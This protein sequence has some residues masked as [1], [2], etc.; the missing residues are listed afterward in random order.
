M[1]D[2]GDR[3]RIASAVTE[4]RHWHPA[5][6]RQ[7]ARTVL[8]EGAST[9]TSDRFRPT[10]STGETHVKRRTQTRTLP[11]LVL[12]GAI[13]TVLA[14]CGGG[15]G[16][17]GG[18]GPAGGDENRD[19]IPDATIAGSDQDN[20]GVDDV[21]V[22][23]DGVPDFDVNQDGVR[24]TDVNR[25]GSVD[26]SVLDEFGLL[27]GFDSDGDGV[28]D[29]D[30][31]GR[32]IDN[33]PG[34]PDALACPNGGTDATSATDQ[35]N[36]NCTLRRG[37]EYDSYYTRGVQRILVCFGFDGENANFADAEYGP[38]TVEQVRAFQSANG[39]T[40][41]G[42]VEPDTWGVLRDTLI[43]LPITADNRAND[44]RSYAVDG[45]STAAACD[46]VQF[47][48]VLATGENIDSATA[49]F[50]GWAIADNP[51]STTRVEFSIRNPF[52]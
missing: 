24:D 27:A 26:P 43:V 5:T 31:N 14:S 12:A 42:V 2:H 29:L 16:D 52:R 7:V 10:D 22:N 13:G 47:Y 34:G 6:C 1:P 19:G 17:G 20:D 33:G 40:A 39:L 44:D 11:R 38:G 36:D 8:Y 30:L 51:G 21:D 37:N 35:W 15:S 50:D 23:G 18:T 32:T 25:D 28:A 49:R 41:N 3:Q 45:T 4:N 46:T 9:A 48:R